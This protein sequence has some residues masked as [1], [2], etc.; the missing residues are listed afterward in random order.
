MADL[1]ADDQRRAAWLTFALI[2]ARPAVRRAGRADRRA[3]A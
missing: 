3:L 1:E 2:G